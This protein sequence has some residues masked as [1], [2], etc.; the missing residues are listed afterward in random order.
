VFSS[1]VNVSL[2]TAF[3]SGGL[4]VAFLPYSFVDIPQLLR[5]NILKREKINY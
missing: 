3:F 1:F 4:L 2:F 5:K